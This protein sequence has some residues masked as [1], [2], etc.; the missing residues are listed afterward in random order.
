MKQTNKNH[1][2]TETPQNF[3]VVGIGASAGGLDAFKKLVREIPVDSGMAY[4]IVQHLS[5]DHDSNLTEILSQSTDIPVHEIINDINLAPD[6]IYIIPENS[7][8]T[9]HDGV[10]KLSPRDRH[11]KRSMPIDIF[12][13]SLA[14]VHKSFAVGV[15]LSGTAFDGTNGLKQIKEVGGATIAQDPES[16]IFKGMP[17]SVIDA[18]A[19]DYILSPERIPSQLI[20]IRDSYV[21]NH[22]YIEEELIPKD[23]EDILK[24]IIKLIYLRTGNDFNHYKQPTIR[25]RIARRMVITK[26]EELVDYF[27]LL[28]NDKNEQDAL[29]NDMLIPVSYFFR[30]QKIFESLSED[31]FPKLLQNVT[32]KNLRVWVA[33]C[34]TGE[35]AYSLAISIHEFLS[36]KGR[37]DIRVQIFASDISEKVIT[38]ARTAVYTPQDLQNVSEIRLNNY[39]TKV[40]GNFHINKVVRDMC[41]FAVHNFIKDPPF[42][43][44]DLV[45]CRNVLI[46]LDTFLQNKAL[47]TF[48]YALKDKGLLFLGKSETAASATNLF[49]PIAKYEKIYIRKFAPGRYVPQSFKPV[50]PLLEKAIPIESKNTNDTD[51]RKIASDI[52]FSKYTPAA[53]IVNDHQDIIHFHGDTSPFLLPSP[54]KPNFNVLKMAREGIEFELRNLLLKMKNERQKTIK[55]NIVVKD[56]QYLASIEIVPLENADNHLLVLFKKTTLPIAEKS[57][58][59]GIRAD[60]QRIK[61]LERELSQLREDIK[62]VTEEQQ[63]AYEELQTTNEELLSSSEELQALNEELETSTEELQSNNEEL[64]CVND[65]LMDRQDQL[66]ALRHYSD[67]IVKTIREPLIVLDKSLRIK[68]V[69]PAFYKYFRTTEQETEGRSLFE[70]GNRQWDTPELRSLLEKVLTE[71]SNIV[72]YNL[73]AT[74]P[75]I[76]QRTLLLNAARVLDAKPYDLMLLAIEDVTEVSKAY[77]VITDKNNQLELYNEQLKSFSWNASHDLQEPLRKIHMFGKL[78]LEEEKQLTE[79]GRHNLQRI[80]KSAANMQQL[81][82]DLMGYTSTI[83]IEK[84]FK[85]IDLNT[86]VKKAITG[87]KD[88]IKETGAV[89]K[90]ESLPHTAEVLPHQFQQLFTNLFVNSI[91]YAKEEQPAIIKIKDGMALSSEIVDLGGNPELKYIKITV[92]DNGIGFNP[93]NAERIFDAFFRLH[94]KDKYRGSGLGLTLSRKIMENHHGF[95]K[96]ESKEDEGTTIHIYLPDIVAKKTR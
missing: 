72:D 64:V 12:F 75:G 92:S 47:A 63:T 65:E 20:H 42:A 28:R 34:S 25:R 78:L 53:V 41:V 70:I 13:N 37:E 80:T 23:E 2:P 46:Y 21:A 89:I 61:D 51:F 19:A 50:N 15:V 69:N 31:I 74:F 6:H 10:L 95:I 94:S 1:Y 26:K 38:K 22:A 54:G 40:D 76:G 33:G 82:E 27:N 91:K 29:F 84:D 14:E 66:M 79:K 85:V 90:V 18:D 4:V 32:N 9:T 36:Q 44:M 71:R 59:N 8:V 16:A 60:Q 30:D 81:I 49:E 17:Q 7:I 87:I 58:D 11:A 48:H 55:E 83:T 86:L 39:F 24:Q 57:A 5:P 56:Q 35:E 3:P 73:T 93:D 43:K 45:T 96:A 68:S 62:R 88:L 67:S 52:I 77:K